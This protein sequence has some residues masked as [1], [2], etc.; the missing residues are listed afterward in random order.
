MSLF[1]R[2]QVPKERK[3]IAFIWKI[4][5]DSYIPE[6]NRL[7]LQ[8]NKIHLEK[9]TCVKYHIALIL[10]GFPAGALSHIE[11]MPNYSITLLPPSDRGRSGF[12]S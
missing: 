12:L 5:Q 3:P 2:N 7:H 8:H 10:K 1:H 9:K 6:L 4:T 11:L